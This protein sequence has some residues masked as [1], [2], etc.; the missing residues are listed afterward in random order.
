MEQI[1]VGAPGARAS[2]ED[3]IAERGGV[4]IWKNINLSNPGGGGI[5]TPALDQ[6]GTPFQKPAWNVERAEVITDI[7][8]FKFVDAWRE[9]KRFHVAVRPGSQGLSLKCTTGSTNRIMAALAKYPG[10]RYRFDYMM[11]E[12]VIEVPEYE[13]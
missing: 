3:W 9:V 4:Q 8:R 2:F 13:A 6:D 11:Q 5:F 10:S 12:A 1:F 7:A